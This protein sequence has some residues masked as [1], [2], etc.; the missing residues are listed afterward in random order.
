MNQFGISDKSFQLLLD[1]FIHYT[2]V[3]EVIL[4]GSRAKGNYKKGSDIDLAIKGEEC[5][6]SLAL[7]LQSY[8]N[9]ELPIPY[10]VD[11]I[12][13]NSLNHKELKEH[14]DRVG[15]KFYKR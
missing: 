1:T 9:E 2:Q 7:T 12:D 11:V 10:T 6:A 15:I 13:Y 8:I 3:E 4:F 14:I 5:S